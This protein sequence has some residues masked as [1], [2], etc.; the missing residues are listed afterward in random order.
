MDGMGFYNVNQR[1]CTVFVQ[2]MPD[3]L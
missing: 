2:S 3:Q 1:Y